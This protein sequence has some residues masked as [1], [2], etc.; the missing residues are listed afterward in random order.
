MSQQ[1]LVRVEQRD[2]ARNIVHQRLKNLT[3]SAQLTLNSFLFGDVCIA[4]DKPNDMSVAHHGAPLNQM[5]ASVWP[6][7]LKAMWLKLKC[8]CAPLS[9]LLNR[10]T[11][12]VLA[13]AGRVHDEVFKGRIRV[14]ALRGQVKYIEKSRVPAFQTQVF[15]KN[16]NALRQVIQHTT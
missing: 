16:R 8:H 3:L 10:V 12:A 6:G 5:R 15:I 1:R 7:A 9:D 2:A 11:L 14:G 4:G 13:A